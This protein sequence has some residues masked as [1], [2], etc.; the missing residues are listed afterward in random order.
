MS[1]IQRDYQVSDKYPTNSLSISR[2]SIAYIHQHVASSSDKCTPGVS[3]SPTEEK[4]GTDK[5]IEL[6]L[7]F[8]G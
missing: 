3:I 4:K 8:G 6:V 1:E 5:T 7:G 2:I